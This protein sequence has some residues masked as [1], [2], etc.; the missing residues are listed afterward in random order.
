[1]LRNTQRTWNDSASFRQTVFLRI[2]AAKKTRAAQWCD[3]VRRLMASMHRFVEKMQVQFET[4][5]TA[6]VQ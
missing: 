5:R 1:M 3:E 2:H 6:A 4:K